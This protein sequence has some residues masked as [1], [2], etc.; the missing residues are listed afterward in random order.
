IRKISPTGVVSTLAGSGSLGSA[1]GTG[2]AASFQGPQ[3]VAVDAGGNVFVAD[4]Q[5]HKIRKISPARVVT[6]LAGSGSGGGADGTGTAAHFN[7]PAG[8]AVDA[9]GNVFVADWG[10]NQIRKISPTG[11]VSTLAGS[12]SLGS[13]DG[14]GVAASFNSPQGVAVNADGNVFIADWKNN[15]IRKG[16]PAMTQHI[17]FP[18]LSDK[19]AGDAPFS[20]SATASS[21]LPVTFSKVTGPATITGNTVT[22]TGS[23]TVIV[24]ASQAGNADYASA[25]NVDQSFTVQKISQT[26]TFPAIGNRLMNNPTVSLT[27]AAAA[28]TTSGLPITYAVASGPATLSG[29]TLTLTGEGVVTVSAS[30]VGNITY[31]PAT[32]TQAF[33]VSRVSQ[34]IN[35]PA[36]QITS[37]I[38]SLIG[39][40]TTTSGLPITYAVV[41]GPA[42]LSGTTLTITADG[43]ITVSANQAGNTEYSPAMVSQTFTVSHASQI[44]TFPT[45]GNRLMTS[46][47]V[48]LT[49]AAAATT[50]SGLPI[51]YAVV[52][53]PATVSGTTL[54]LTGEGLVTVSASQG[55]SM[56]YNQASVT[57][58][59]TVSRVSQPI[60]FPA[61]GNRLLTTPTV[62]LTGAAAATTISGLPITY[63][64]VSGPATLSGT[65][66]TLTGEGTVTVSASQA[67]NAVYSPTLTSQSFMV[68][69]A[70]QVI[71]F[72]ALADRLLGKA[73]VITLSATTS[74]A[75]PVTYS[76]LTGPAL[77]SGSTLT[78]T[79]AGTITVKAVQAG[80]SKYLPA[81]DACVSFTVFPNTAAPSSVTLSKNWFYDNISSGE[82]IAVLSSVDPDNGDSFVYTLVSGTGSTDNA[83]FTIAGDRLK[84]AAT[85]NYLT[86]REVSIRVKTVDVAGQPYEQVLILKVLPARPNARFIEAG[87]FTLPPD[88][89]L[90]NKSLPY[91]N[92]IFQLVG[93]GTG[94]GINYP[95][96]FFDP[97]SPDYQP[98]LFQAF[99]GATLTSPT[100]PI[101]YNES[102]FQV[103]KI[104][105]VPSKV[106]TV[107][108]LDCSSSISIADMA[109]IKSAAK[110]MVDN[111]FEEQEIAVYS[112]SG[113]VTMLQSFLGKSDANQVTLKAAIDTLSRGSGT[114]NLYGSMLQ[115][116]NLKDWKESFTEKGIETGFLVV[117][118]DGA[119]SSGSSTKEQVKD[120]RD[121]VANQGREVRRIYTIGLGAGIEPAVLE[122]L[123]NMDFYRRVSQ[124]GDLAAAF[125]DIQQDIIDLANSFY[126]FNYISPKRVSNPIGTLRKLEVKLKNN[127][128]SAADRL[129]SIKFNSDLF[130]DLAPAIYINRT[131]YE[132]TGIN[133]PKALEIE[134]RVLPQTAHGITLFPPSDFS[135]FTWSIG[136]P[137]LATLTPE[138]TIGERVVITPNG[139]I[140][141]TT[142]TLT[143]TISNFTKTS[144]AGF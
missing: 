113:T 93:K 6:T 101:A 91:V 39:G 74:S 90:G 144:G 25:P 96:S 92:A 64:L 30:Q 56:T 87:A 54:T 21:G 130:Q 22:L 66:L 81:A 129:L 49:G 103:G 89:A 29:T 36:L 114:T 43:T 65:T 131:V 53:G 142:L 71:T 121:D 111:M 100:S 10:N 82:E 48:S 107:L 46:P 61:I 59:F 134:S 117:L 31:N 40:A 127:T 17:T 11:V 124:A 133:S 84:A 2:A 97:G 75:L 27:G 42:T 33:T 23:G 83:K 16:V 109:L 77:I 63:A 5:N 9:G 34:T 73:N 18:A 68:S 76:L 24:R 14:T 86:Q 128:N 72:P 20:V 12:G 104:S 7:F 106:R 13:A 85:F 141:T 108:L 94:R 126:Q 110:V 125:D 28:T 51:T 115:M 3:G 140:G 26:I 102:Y 122:D 80:S 132:V 88:V 95:R 38:V 143:D 47:T 120:K 62:S 119:D 15:K 105:D 4:Q 35:F 137:A 123:E 67:G 41:S 116:L 136:N 138:G 52:S 139:L 57:Q 19:T 69:R 8:V 98:D 45:I 70:S 60:T 78:V 58:T 99:E 112:F 1:D 44:I 32:V 37:P 50:T 118:T 79:A 55:G 135:S